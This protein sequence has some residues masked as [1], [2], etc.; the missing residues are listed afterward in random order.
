MALAYPGFLEWVR[1]YSIKRNFSHKL[2]SWS[3]AKKLGI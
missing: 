1:G 3:E 2:L